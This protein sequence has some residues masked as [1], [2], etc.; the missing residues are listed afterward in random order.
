MFSLFVLVVAMLWRSY[1]VDFFV[2]CWAFVMWSS[3][4]YIIVSSIGNI[5]LVAVR[6]YG[7]IIANVSL[8]GL[9]PLT[10][11]PV[12]GLITLLIIFVL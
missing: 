7:S 5:V 3:F 1:I 4:L 8:V 6:G 2:S 10:T 12:D 9:F 11:E